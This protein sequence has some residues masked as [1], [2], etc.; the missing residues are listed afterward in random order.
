MGYIYIIISYRYLCVHVTNYVAECTQL[1]IVMFN[2]KWHK[3][4]YSVLANITLI[5]PLRLM[6]SLY[7]F[8]WMFE[9]GALRNGIFWTLR[10]SFYFGSNMINIQKKSL[11]R[12]Q[13]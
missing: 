9:E 6:W 8:T 13:P 1:G 11:H 7:F 3:Y 12:K 4:Y 2:K 10:C 5:V